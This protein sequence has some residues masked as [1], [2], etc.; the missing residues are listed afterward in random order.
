M[1]GNNSANKA[2]AISVLII[3][4]INDFSFKALRV[5]ARILFILNKN[6]QVVGGDRLKHACAPVPLIL[7]QALKYPALV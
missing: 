7:D 5:A 1:S 2:V 3:F 4:K 6:G